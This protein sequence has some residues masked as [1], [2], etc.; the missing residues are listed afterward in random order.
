LLDSF[1]ALKSNQRENFGK[2]VSA[3]PVHVFRRTIVPKAMV[4]ATQMRAGD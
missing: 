1:G 4:Y 3:V 2:A